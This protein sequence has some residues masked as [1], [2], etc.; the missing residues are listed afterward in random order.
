MPIY[1][2]GSG[3]TGGATGDIRSPINIFSM[4]NPQDIESVSVLKDASAAAIYGVRASNGVI[5]ITTKK[6]KAGRPKVELSS[7]FGIQN[8]PKTYDVLNTQ[9]YYTLAKEM[10]LANP[11]ANTSF[12]QKFGPRYDAASPLYGGNNPTYNWQKE[13]LNKDA[14]IQDHR[15]CVVYWAYCAHSTRLALLFS[16]R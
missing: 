3:V 14:V 2:G 15:W 11:D 10:Y 5:I 6:G 1:E 7:T 8:I 16:N 12:E 9:D 4:I 13:L